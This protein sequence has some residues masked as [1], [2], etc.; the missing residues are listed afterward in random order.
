MTK[1]GRAQPPGQQTIANEDTEQQQHQ[2][3]HRRAYNDSEDALVVSDATVERGTRGDA[4]HDV[5]G[6]DGCD[7]TDWY[8]GHAVDRDRG[9]PGKGRKETDCAP[10]DQADCSAYRA[11]QEYGHGVEIAAFGARGK[12]AD[13]ASTGGTD[14]ACGQASQN[15]SSVV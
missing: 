13:C 3:P 5:V 2:C 9:A 11:N 6:S 15:Q 10:E 4:K 8:Q 12:E 1:L 14:C 7:Q